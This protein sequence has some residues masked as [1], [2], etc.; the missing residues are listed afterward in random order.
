MWAI[1]RDFLA[2]KELKQA[3]KGTNDNAQGVRGPRGVALSVAE[4]VAHPE[5]QTFRMLDDDRNV[6]YQGAFV[7][8]DMFE[9]LDNFG[10]PN[11]GCTIIEFKRGN[12]WVMV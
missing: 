2:E 7:G 12:A 11:A 6:Y 5:A 8:S 1:T 3:P 4:I 9:P 10:A